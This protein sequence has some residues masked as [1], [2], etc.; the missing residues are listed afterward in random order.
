MLAGCGL[1]RG[2]RQ[3]AGC[4]SS[5]AIMPRRSARCAR[6][7]TWT[8]AVTLC[9]KRANAA[10]SA[11]CSASVRREKLTAE[12]RHSSTAPSSPR[13][14]IPS[15]S[16]SRTGRS[17][18]AGSP[19]VRSRSPPAHPG[20][21]ATPSG[22][23]T[24]RRGAR[25]WPSATSASRSSDS[26]SARPSASTRPAAS[27]GLTTP[28]ATGSGTTSRAARPSA[29]PTTAVAA[30]IPSCRAV[31]P[32]SSRSSRSTL[33]GIRF[34]RL[35]GPPRS[36]PPPRGRSGTP[37]RTWPAAPACFAAR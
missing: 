14:M 16:R 28:A 20:G 6:T 3:P 26:P 34:S 9:R 18:G 5:S 37:G 23:G 11:C 25:R 17:S 13:S 32:A 30:T 19:P 2:M 29:Q 27:S 33:A 1:Q 15:G 24:S 10:T 12:A 22:A 4:W 7:T 31:S 35:T 8:G 36:L 21:A